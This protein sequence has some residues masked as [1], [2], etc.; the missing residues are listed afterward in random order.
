MNTP[1][2]ITS[3]RPDRQSEAH[4]VLARIESG[5]ADT[6][7]TCGATFADGSAI[8]RDPVI[9]WMV[10]DCVPTCK[11]RL[12]RLKSGTFTTTT[13]DVGAGPISCVVT[14]RHRSG[15]VSFG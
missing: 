1:N 10:S 12:G 8:V 15:L 2:T 3:T 4:A 11:C 14:Y 6:A 5:T 13:V 7:G 9:G